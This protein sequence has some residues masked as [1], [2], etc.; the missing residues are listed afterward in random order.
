MLPA[1]DPD[2]DALL[3]E[4]GLGRPGAD[5]ALA[6]VRELQALLQRTAA[7]EAREQRR[8]EERT[9]QGIELEALQKR[10]AAL[11]QALHG[12]DGTVT[13]R[14]K[15]WP[16]REPM[17]RKRMLPPGRAPPVVSEAPAGM[18]LGGEASAPW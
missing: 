18:K 6:D 9:R 10:V 15:S 1:G 17:L 14:S 3:C 2:V 8:E 13:S 12:R 16:L 11:E 7:L 4:V 5:G